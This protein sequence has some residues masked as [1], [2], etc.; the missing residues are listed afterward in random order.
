MCGRVFYNPNG[1][2][3]WDDGELDRLAANPNATA[4]DWACGEVFIDGKTYA[5]DCTCWHERGLKILQWIL[6]HDEEIAAFLTFEKARK[7]A[8]AKRSPI[9]ETPA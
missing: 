3:D 7:Q 1:S 5:M 6:A 2:W 9:V 4:K 8:E